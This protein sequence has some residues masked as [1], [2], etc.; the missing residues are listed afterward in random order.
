MPRCCEA[1][2]GWEESR[3]GHMCI[4]AMRTSHGCVFRPVVENLS[5]KPQEFARWPAR[6]LLP[7]DSSLCLRFFVLRRRRNNPVNPINPCLK[8][9]R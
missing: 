7:S 3:A 8:A 9:L 2:S 5:A 6:A 1:I 4:D